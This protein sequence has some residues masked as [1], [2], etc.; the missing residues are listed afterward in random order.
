MSIPPGH[1]VSLSIDL[2]IMHSVIEQHIAASP[3]VVGIELARQVDRYVREQ[4][5]G[6][7]PALDYFHGKDIIDSDLYNTAESIAWLLENITQQ[8]L[9]K[10]LRPLLS[11]L[12]FDSTHAHLFILPHVR[13]SQN[14][15]IHN[16]TA[17]FTPDHLRVSLSGRLK[18]GA[19]TQEQL[20]QDAVQ[21]IDASLDKH[22][23]LHEIYGIKLIS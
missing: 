9:N 11:E 21:K 4:R 12:Q 13:P 14:N 22:F 7:Y 18:F 10:H 20:L 5:L 3:Y 19:E 6:Y 15:A 2:K 1:K 23:S 16:L 17:H 8:S